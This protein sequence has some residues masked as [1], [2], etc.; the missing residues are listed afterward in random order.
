[1][2]LTGIIYVDTT[3]SM[4]GSFWDLMEMSPEKFSDGGNTNSGQGDSCAL[5]QLK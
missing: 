1:M 4:A 3:I 2:Q 5:G